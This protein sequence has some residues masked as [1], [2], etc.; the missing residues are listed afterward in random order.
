[1]QLLLD[2]ATYFSY[3]DLRKV[4]ILAYV[5][6]ARGHQIATLGVARK[7]A[8]VFCFGVNAVT[9]GKLCSSTGGDDY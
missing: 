6:E 8:G 1:M 7:E 4:V 5:R 2:F 3:N 9:L